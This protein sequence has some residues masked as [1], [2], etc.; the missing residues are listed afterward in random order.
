MN[1]LK[2]DDS[3]VAERI[4]NLRQFMAQDNFY[5]NV[6]ITDPAL[7]HLSSQLI[8]YID[9]FTAYR[10]VQWLVRFYVL[11]YMNGK[12]EATRELKDV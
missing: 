8:R 6:L 9:D 11:G 4:K 5:A 10:G 12:V 1:E 3:E 7:G 2:S